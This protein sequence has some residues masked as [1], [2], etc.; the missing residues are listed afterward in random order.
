MCGETHLL[1]ALKASKA[2]VGLWGWGRLGLTLCITSRTIRSLLIIFWVPC[3]R[4][5]V[6]KRP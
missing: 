3:R 1:S 2:G 6:Y 5:R 4:G